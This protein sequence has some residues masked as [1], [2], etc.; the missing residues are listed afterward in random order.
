MS[1]SVHLAENEK[2]SM[3]CAFDVGAGRNFIQN[4]GY[5]VYIVSSIPENLFITSFRELLLSIT[6]S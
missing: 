4:G 6:L 3:N 2:C 5:R 1:I